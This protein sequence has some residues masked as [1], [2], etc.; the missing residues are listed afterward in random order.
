MGS[1]GLSAIEL[2]S[3]IRT[4]AANGAP[5]SLDYYDGELEK[6]TDLSTIALFINNTLLPILN[7]LPSQSTSGLLGTSCYSDIANQDPLVY[8]SSTGNFLT[9]TQS[10]R[11]L[12]G[13]LQTMQ[14]TVINLTQQVSSLQARLSSTDQDDLSLALQ[15][16]TTILATNSD[17]IQVLTTTIEG[18]STSG[19]G[20]VV[21][22]ETPT[23]DPESIES[24]AIMWPASFTNNSY[25]VSYSLQDSSGFL[26]ILSFTYMSG[27]V[28]IN[29]LV[30]NSD[31][32]ASHQGYVLAQGN[33]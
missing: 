11:L 20:S 25:M 27:G 24:V 31:T 23:I 33:I 28:G 19:F 2:T 10:M 13:Q 7:A 30:R 5:S 6:A 4:A 14:T 8:D 29:V 22:Q 1:I 26:S 32:A 12:N 3:I 21:T 18:L 15:N 16:I 9:V 17:Q